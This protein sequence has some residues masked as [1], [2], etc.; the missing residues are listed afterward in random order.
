[1]IPIL[2]ASLAIHCGGRGP[3]SVVYTVL[4]QSR[5]E[6]EVGRSGAFGFLGHDH[7]I[8]ARAFRGRAVYRPAAPSR[9]QVEVVVRADS[10]EVLTPHDTAEIRKVTEVMRGQVLQAGRHP[11]IRFISHD[12]TPGEHGFRVRGDL[13]ITGVTRGIVVDVEATA[14]GDTLRAQGR[15][16]VKQTDFGLTPVRAGGGTVRV[17]DRVVITLDVVALRDRER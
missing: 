6:V 10:L 3:D 11:E 13:T 7:L 8:R 1:M 5:F 2:L 12:V 15:F 17:A 14:G 9:S 4:P 16:A